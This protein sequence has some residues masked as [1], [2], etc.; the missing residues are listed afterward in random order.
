MPRLKDVIN[1]LERLA[2]TSLAENWDNVGLMLGKPNAKVNKVL[3]AL[4]LNE[5]VVDEAI[6]L[7]VQCVITHHPFFFKAMKQ[8]NLESIQGRM[9][10]KLI[11][12]QI[13]VYS[14]HTN[15]DIAE[16]GLNDY[17]MQKLGILKTKVLKTTYEE[18]LYKGTIYVPD[19]YLEQVRSVVISHMKSKLGKY[20]GCTFTKQGEGTFMPLEGSSPYIGKSGQ[21]EKVKES[22]LS[23]V[24]TYDEIEH[25]I[26]AAQKVHPYEEVAVDI[27]PLEN[28]KKSYG[29]G[30]YGKLDE[31]VTMKQFI[32]QVKA[33]FNIE[34]IR[35]TDEMQR[36]VERVALCSGSGSELIPLA[37][38]VADVYITGD[39]K[40]HEGQMAQSMGITVI[41]VGHYASESIALAPIGDCIKQAFPMCEVYHSSINGETLFVK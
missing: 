18:K 41:D 23:F 2:P 33:C 40:F 9:I 37:A 17:L 22:Q 24:G 35:I 34:H 32:R 36:K 15:Y 26:E 5:S 25:I 14:M 6:N 27:Y 12:N 11:L 19:A 13:A 31:A 16:G 3:C 28:M 1:E 30:R 8:I 21:L 38:R 20:S 10:E 29:I 4:D 7:G 39:V